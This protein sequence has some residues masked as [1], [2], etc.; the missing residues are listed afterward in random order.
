[1][2]DSY[3]ERD[4]IQPE[5]KADSTEKITLAFSEGS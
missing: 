1:M 2:P 3:K 5:F 4:L